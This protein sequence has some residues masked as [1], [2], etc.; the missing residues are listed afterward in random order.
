MKI[1]LRVKKITKNM[2]RLRKQMKH[3][4]KMTL[5]RSPGVQT[6]PKNAENRSIE[7]NR[8]YIHYYPKTAKN[9]EQLINKFREKK[10]KTPKKHI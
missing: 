8:R 10:T 7:W 6:I 1:T 2:Q 3:L 4:C 9:R 5:L